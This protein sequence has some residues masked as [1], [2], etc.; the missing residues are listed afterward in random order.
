MR[1]F[2]EALQRPRLLAAGHVTPTDAPHRRWQL[3]CPQ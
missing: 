1:D 3:G 2:G